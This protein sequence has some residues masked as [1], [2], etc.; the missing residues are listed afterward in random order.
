MKLKKTIPYNA[1]LYSQLCS[2]ASATGIFGGKVAAPDRY[3]HTVSLQDQYTHFCGGSL[4]ARDVVLSAAHCA[5]PWTNW[6]RMTKWKYKVVIGRQI[7]D[8]W[9]EGG[10]YDVRKEV[11]HPKYFEGGDRGIIEISPGV[12]SLRIDN[13]FML[14]ILKKSVANE[15]AILMNLNLNVSVPDERAALTVVGWGDST[16]GGEYLP[17]NTLLE[18]KGHAISNEEC[19]LRRGTNM[20]YEGA[21]TSNELCS[22]EFDVDHFWTHEGMCRGDSGGP[23]IIPGDGPENDVQVGV[24]SWGPCGSNRQLP[25]VYARLSSQYEWIAQEVC[26]WSSNPPSSFDCPAKNG[27]TKLTEI[28]S[29]SWPFVVLGVVVVAA[30]GAVIA[31]GRR[32]KISKEGALL[33]DTSPPE[34]DHL[35][36]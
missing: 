30:L 11:L 10:D 36:L 16:I 23:L 1:L 28:V 13:D 31:V 33:E 2:T 20:T 27:S 17:S 18:A 12:R 15:D 26:K 29:S 24:V 8:E 21:I 25:G 6:L 3:P 32:N 19:L 4:I 9:E 34:T 35:I 14:V 22:G 7:L 5:R